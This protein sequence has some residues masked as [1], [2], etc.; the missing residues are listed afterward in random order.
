MYNFSFYYLFFIFT[1]VIIFTAFLGVRSKV[2]R[3]ERGE[4]AYFLA[5]TRLVMYT[6]AT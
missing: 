3:R 6:A 2:L 4:C 5:A 1:I